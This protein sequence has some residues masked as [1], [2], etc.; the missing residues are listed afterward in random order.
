[1][2]RFRYRL[3]G[4]DHDWSSPSTS[5]EAYFTDLSPGSYTFRVCAGNVDGAWG[6]DSLP[7]VMILEPPVYQSTAF[8]VAVSLAIAATAVLAYRL[9]VAR[10][11]AR[12]RDL[13]ALVEQRTAE[14]RA[15]QEAAEQGS[16][17]KDQFLAVLS[18]EL[19]TPL[20]P[21]LLSV[22]NLLEDDDTPPAVREHLEMIRR[23][24]ELE[25]RLVGDLLDVSRIERGHLRL[26]LE[27]LDVHEVIGRALE[28]CFAELFTA[29]LEVVEKLK[30]ESHYA[31]ADYARLMQIFWNLIRNAAK[32]APPGRRLTI[33][34]FNEGPDR[35]VSESAFAGAP[36]PHGRLLVVEFQDNGIGIEPEMLGR[37]FDPFEQGSEES[38]RRG[39]GLGLG[40]TIGR[41]VAEAHGGRLTASSP[42]KGL[43]ATFRL[44][45][46]AAPGPA[47]VRIAG[48]ADD[49][50]L[51][52]AGLRI[53]LVED[54]ADTL[55]YLDLILRRRGYEVVPAASLAAARRAAA[56]GDYDLLIS[57]IELSD[58]SGLELMSDLR[59]RAIPG[60]ALSGH[61]S[62]DDLEQS[63][64]AGFATH[65]VK[66]VLAEALD[67]AIGRVAP[68]SRV[69]DAQAAAMRGPSSRRLAGPR[70]VGQPLRG[71]SG[72]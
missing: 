45:L 70:P 24:I 50:R 42:G 60:I 4:Y 1:M 27:L 59:H 57:D 34:S 65:L 61:G 51:R 3:E 2:V 68:A 18:H 53:L 39:S 54:N 71:P 20:T 43:G 62:E 63:R 55:R 37:I 66:P 25:A 30:A 48:S 15:A 69:R 64:A 26:E 22:G 6:P 23:N 38:R 41:G 29:E 56:A 21:V 16:R 52:P 5:R 35:S 58:G 46:A 28:V 11:R 47:Q 14:A 9:R 36:E 32:F 12:E 17:A 33:R 44:E 10:L 40:L 8:R 19:R 67:E 49:P 7:L 13:V 31:R 72:A